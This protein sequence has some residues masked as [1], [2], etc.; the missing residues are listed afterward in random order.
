[1]DTLGRS[2]AVWCCPSG[3]SDTSAT[4]EMPEWRDVPFTVGREA[5]VAAPSCPHVAAVR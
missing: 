2:R 3:D 4:A 5:A 1:M